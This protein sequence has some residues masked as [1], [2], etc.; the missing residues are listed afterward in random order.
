MEELIEGMTKD[1]IC[2]VVEGIETNKEL[3]YQLLTKA[4]EL[5]DSLDYQVVV[6]STGMAEE[7]ELEQLCNYG[8][9]T[10]YHC[11]LETEDV[12]QLADLIQS[13]LKKI[14]SIKLIMF[15]STRKGQAVAAILSIRF[16]AGLTAE[17]IDIKYE[18]GFVYT[19]AAMN[20]S[21]MAEIRVKNST[22]GMCT[23]KENAFR[24]EVK[25]TNRK[26]NIIHYTHQDMKKNLL[27]R[28]DIL[29]KSM[30]KISKDNFIIKNGRIIFGCGRGVLTS[31]CLEL[32]LQVA[33]K[34]KA[35]IACTRPVVECGAMD[36]ES[37]V[38]QSGKNIAPHIYI[39]FGISGASQ[40]IAGVMNSSIIIAV[41]NDE[42]APIFQFGNYNLVADVK[43]VLTGLLQYE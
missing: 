6:V 1:C 21:V 25:N 11:N 18:N 34:Y 43:E 10:V 36:F 29:I 40:H 32:F 13:I 7:E 4:R 42:H 38:G 26:N 24:K 20:S 22:F 41:N 3:S 5:A 19:R 23:I 35:E 30:R 14:I 27:G 39:A 33:E 12:H 2:V 15:S 31:G 17:C 9:D 8:A 37:Q 28:D 16:G